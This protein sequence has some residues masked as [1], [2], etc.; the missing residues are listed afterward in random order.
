LEFAADCEEETAMSEESSV[1]ALLGK[2]DEVSQQTSD[3]DLW[4]PERLSLRGAEV[5][6]DMAMAVVLDRLVGKGFMPAGF[7]QNA[8]GRTYH[9]KRRNSTRG[10]P[11]GR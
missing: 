3:F 5:P 8:N 10:E 7:T 4:V 9:Y 1:E 11:L 2:I 6:S